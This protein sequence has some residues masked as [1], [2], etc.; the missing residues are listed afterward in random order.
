MSGTPEASTACLTRA[1]QLRA[2]FI[3]VQVFDTSAGQ[4]RAEVE[5]KG[6][7]AFCGLGCRRGER[8]HPA[9]VGRALSAP[10]WRLGYPRAAVL[11]EVALTNSRDIRLYRS[12]RDAGWL[13][14]TPVE[15]VDYR[16]VTDATLADARQFDIRRLTIDAKFQGVQIAQT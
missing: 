4:P 8:S 5:I 7:Q 13:T 16:R 2:H 11:A 6:H 1:F 10:A 12:W 14:L 3:R 9:R 15:M